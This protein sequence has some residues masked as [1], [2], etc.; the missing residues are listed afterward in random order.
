MARAQSGDGE[1]YRRL[2]EAIVPYLRSFAAR[3]HRD[4][5]D[6]EDT[7]QDV[8]LTLHAS[9]HTYDPARPFIPWLVAIA[10][11]RVI[12]RLRQQG[13][14]RLRDAA[15]RADHETFGGPQANIQEIGLGG[16]ALRKAVEN[17]P[18][19]QRQAVKLL[20]LQEMSLRQASNVSGT[21]IASLK[22]AMHRAL[23]N[24]RTMLGKK[25][26]ES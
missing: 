12:D 16:Y 10:H 8:L 9:R 2:L 21:S 11:R 19:G 15:L 3:R 14:A 4:P 18:P 5:R 1:A 13:R 26:E 20:K 17:L 24:L 23:K 7:V 22:V 25:S 6:A